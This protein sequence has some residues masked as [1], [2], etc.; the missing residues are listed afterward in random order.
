[1]RSCGACTLCCTLLPVAEIGKASGTRCR[2][3]KFAKGCKLYHNAAM[4]HS[5]RLWNCRWLVND[6]TNDLSRPDRSH[7][8]IDL[9]PDF[10]T[11]TDNDTGQQQHIGVVQVWCDPKH[12]DAHRDPQFRAYVERRAAQGH[13]VLVR[14]NS[15]EAITLFAPQLSSDGQWHEIGGEA[16]AQHTLQDFGKFLGSP[17]EPDDQTEITTNTS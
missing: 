7:L 15:H 13:A 1:M 11:L 2:H 8:V 12:R 4:P 16:E 5:C 17:G 14:F 6:D 9:M 10:I 3:Q